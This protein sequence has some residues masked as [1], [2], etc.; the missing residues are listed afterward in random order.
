MTKIVLNDK[1]LRL[2]KQ[3]ALNGVPDENGVIEHVE[4][5]YSSDEM[6]IL[7]QLMDDAD[8]LVKELDAEE[9]LWNEYGGSSLE[10]YYAK[11][12]AQGNT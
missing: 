9:E 12:K 6:D 8:E 2:L 1:Q 4:Y 11:Y 10:W 5:F 3:E 7:S